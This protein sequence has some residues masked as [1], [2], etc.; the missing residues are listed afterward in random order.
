MDILLQRVDLLFIL[1]NVA[2]DLSA[3][4]LPKAL[5]ERLHLFDIVVHIFECR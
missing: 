1:P 5:D 2:N 4:L 3:I